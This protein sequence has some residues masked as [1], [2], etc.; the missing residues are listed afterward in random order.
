MI[1]RCEKI[2]PETIEV[3]WKASD[4]EQFNSEEDAIKHERFCE[5]YQMQKAVFKN[6]RK[7]SVGY[8]PQN[9]AQRGTGYEHVFASTDTM[10]DWLVSNENIVMNFY[11]KIGDFNNE[12]K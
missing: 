1:E 8:W 3:Y 12:T 10:R 4:G 2:I 5:V 11:Q 9:T 6:V 7:D